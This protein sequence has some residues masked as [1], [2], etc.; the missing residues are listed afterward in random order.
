MYHTSQ[1]VNYF[2]VL[3]NEER[4]AV[5]GNIYTAIHRDLQIP[6]WEVRMQLLPL[7]AIKAVAEVTVIVIKPQYVMMIQGLCDLVIF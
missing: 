3:V 4:H 5:G 6:L 2:Y 7:F 1:T